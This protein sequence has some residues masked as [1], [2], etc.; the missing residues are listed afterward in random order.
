MRSEEVKILDCLYSWPYY[1]IVKFEQFY[2]HIW[3]FFSLNHLNT[4]ILIFY[5]DNCGLGED[6]EECYVHAE[7]YLYMNDIK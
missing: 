7:R 1:N 3:F 6:R 5:N 2:M 4:H